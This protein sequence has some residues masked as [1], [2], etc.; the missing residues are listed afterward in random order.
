VDD[1][2]AG[3]LAALQHGEVG[4]HYI[5]GGQ[6]VGLAALLGEIANLSGRRPPRL[7]LPRSVLYPLAFLAETKARWTQCEPFLT[8]DGLRMA[9]Y[10]M[11]FS[12]AKAQRDLAYCARPYEEGLAD[13]LAWFGQHGYLK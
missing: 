6:N 10:R 5:L 8:R 12:S 13:A 9:K 2:A 4:E 11:F 3:H 1:V 7:R